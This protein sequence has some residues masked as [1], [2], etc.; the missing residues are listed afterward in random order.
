MSVAWL[1]DPI[2]ESVYTQT[3]SNRNTIPYAEYHLPYRGII[4]HLLETTR[5]EPQ[6]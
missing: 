2:C 5:Q 1:N 4:A 6:R 3:H